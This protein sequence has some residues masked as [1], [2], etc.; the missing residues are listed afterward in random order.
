MRGPLDELR[1]SV[2]VVGVNTGV[3]YE[4]FEVGKLPVTGEEHAARLINPNTKI[5][6]MVSFTF[7]PYD[8][9]LG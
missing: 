8:L 4:P 7:L 9:F 2:V 6:E 5:T 1:A 3:E